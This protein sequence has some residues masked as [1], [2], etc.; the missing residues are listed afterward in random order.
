MIRIAGLSLLL[1]LAACVTLLYTV[2]LPGGVDGTVPGSLRWQPPAEGTAMTGG[3]TIEGDRVILSRFG[4]A[5][6]PFPPAEFDAAAYPYLHLALAESTPKPEIVL[7]WRTAADPDTSHTYALETTSRQ[8]LWI[9]TGELPG[10]Q[11]RITT[12][13]LIIMGQADSA[14]TIEDF[15]LHTASLG[16]QLRAIYSDLT[17]FVPWNRSSMNAHTGARRVA[18][19]YPAPL[20]A[21]LFLASLAIYLGLC[22]VVRKLRFSGAVAGLIFLVAWIGLDLVWNY[23][24][25]QQVAATRAT[26]AGKST[27]EKLAIGPDAALHAFVTASR[28]HI[29]Q[30]DARIF[31]ASSDEYTGLRAAYYFYPFNAFWQLRGREIPRRHHLRSGDY[32]ALLNPNTTTF[33]TA[34]GTL[35]LEAGNLAVETLNSDSVG[36]LLR[37]R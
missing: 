18:S 3:A 8:S 32:I 33:D 15:S 35:V 27:P 20:F 26:F 1:G 24:L 11:G 29:P 9:A 12:L 17:A 23:R 6:V 31:V 37:V 4:G 19:F 13:H 7:A 30:A 22:L 21:T 5:F 16:A 36:T 28:A 14:I 2:F 34:N 10:W 25:V